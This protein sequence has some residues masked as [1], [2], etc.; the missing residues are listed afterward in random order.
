MFSFWRKK[1]FRFLAVSFL[2]TSL[3]VAQTLPQYQIELFPILVLPAAS[4]LLL[5]LALGRLRGVEWL[6]FPILP[7]SLAL[8]T[9][10]GQWFFP[11]FHPFVKAAS[12]LA[13]FTGFY[14][15]LLALN[16]FKVGRSRKESIPLEKAAKPV[17]FMAAFAAAFLLLTALYKVGLG[18]I[19]NSVLIFGLTFILATDAFWFLTTADLLERRFF[20]AGALLALAAVQITLAFSFFPWKVHLRGISEATFFYSALGVSRAYFEKH[21]KY[22]IVVEYILV[23]LTIFAISALVK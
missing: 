8:G 3:L 21:L 13:F 15:L 18:A 2:L 22:S 12:W 17:V 5:P 11:N 16:I 1:R 10:L 4:L 14:L 23:S 20:A 9:A 7:F 19:L 6:T